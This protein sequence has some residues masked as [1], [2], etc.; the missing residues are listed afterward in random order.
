MKIYHPQ[1]LENIMHISKT[2]KIYQLDSLWKMKQIKEQLS[3]DLPSIEIDEDIDFSLFG[4]FHTE[5]FVSALTQGIGREQV[6][7]SCGVFWQPHLPIAMYNRAKCVVLAL[8][9]VLDNESI[10]AVIADGGHHTTPFRAYGF[11]P[12]NSIGIAVNHKKDQ[13]KDKKI[14][15]LDL[16]THQ[17]NGF[18]FIDLPNVKIFDIWSKKLEKWEVHNKNKNYISSKVTTYEEWL[19]EFNAVLKK[20]EEY[21]PD[22]LIYYSGAD[23]IETDRMGGIPGFT[24][25]NFKKR[26]DNLF[27]FLL[28]KNIRLLLTLG[29]GYVDYSKKDVG[30]ERQKLVDTH[31]Y[32]IKSAAKHFKKI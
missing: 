7:E 15:I 16:D 2:G 22:I 30:I 18:S 29:G 4:S 12:I 25:K 13:L 24:L 21:S 17:G 23:V 19:Q 26:E 31:I 11:G 3:T 28:E 6:L 32:S 1:K 9:D 5:E 14:A 27:K 10:A 8:E 20:I